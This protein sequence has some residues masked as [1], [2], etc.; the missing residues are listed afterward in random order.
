[1]ARGNRQDLYLAVN[2]DVRGLQNTVKVGRTVL[3]EFGSTAGNVLEEVERQFQKIGAGGL[4]A[5]L[6]ETER[7]YTET[8]RR[9]GAAAR[10]AANAP[11]GQA[12]IQILDANASRA[13]ADAA[14]NK[15]AALRIVAEAA[16]K[17]DQATGG[18]SAA[19]RAYAVAAATAAVE[20][21]KEAAAL[22][23]QA[24]IIGT[25]E[26]QLVGLTGA[27]Q[28]SRVMSGQ[29]RA[30]Y[31]QLSYQLG[32][33]SMQYS[34]GTSASIIFA[35]QSG[36]VIQAL[37]LI[38]G[39]GNKVLS[40]LGGPWGIA[41]SSALVVATPFVAKLLEGGD[42]AKKE[43]DQL[44]ENAEKAMSAADAKKIFAATEAGAIDDVRALTE[45][46]EKQNETLKTNAERLNI[47]AKQRL[48]TLQER[49][50]D[51]QSQ[52]DDANAA[53]AQVPAS[54]GVAGTASVAANEAR[55]RIQELEATLKRIDGAIAKA[56]AARLRT[57]ADLAGEAAQRAT[58]E[59][60]AINYRYEGANGLIEQAKKR[61][62]AEGTVDAVLTRQLKTLRDQQKA[63]VDTAQKREQA[64]KSSAKDGPLTTFIA[65]VNGTVSG[66][67]KEQRVG[68]QHAGIDYAV[69]VGTAVRAPAAGTIDVA[70]QRQGYGNAIYINFGGGT[71]A[72][73]GHLSKFNV[74]PGDRVEAGD[75]IGYS[76]GEPGTPGA[77]R[78][79]GAHLH[80]EV[81]RGGKAV[82]P[83]TGKF[84]TDSGGV[85]DSAARRQQAEARRQEAE[86]NRRVQ[87][88]DA[89]ASLLSQAQEARY[90][91]ERSRAVTIAEAA[92]LDVAAVERQRADFDRALQKGVE[93]ERW[94]QAEADAVKL[95]TAQNAAG[96]IAAIRLRET[97][98]TITERA[99][100]ER[101]ALDDQA[102]LLRL[103]GELATT[104]ADR[105][106]IARKLLKI[107]QDQVELALKAQIA[108][109]RDPARR[110]SLERR[111]AQ[112]PA[113][114]QLREQAL[115]R[116]NADPL[117]AYGQQ[118]VDATTDM[119]E[120][121]K[122]VAANG[123]GALEDASSRAA[124]RAVTD[125]LKIRGVAGDVV[126]GIIQDLVRLAVQKAIVSA[127]GTSFFGLKDGGL[128]PGFADGGLP[129]FAFGGRPSVDRG[130]IRG[131]GTGRSDSILALVGGQMPILVSN[132]EGIVN[133]RAVQQYWPLI[134]A[135]NKGTFPRFADGGLPSVPTLPRYPSIKAAQK[136]L[137]ESRREQLE[138]V[139][140]IRVSPTKEFDARMETLAVRTVGAAAEP[141]MAGAQSRTITRLRRPSLPGGWG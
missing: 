72:R 8:F 69:P 18:N 40:I 29:A 83:R 15:A 91:I 114:Y 68:H 52:L 89:Y 7:A 77:G 130:L 138:V 23:E 51:V 112:T 13:A 90:R 39:E 126:N 27:Q 59:V 44:R 117:Q 11:T 101:D 46:L 103:Q 4:P 61:A 132:G 78:S 64:A 124:A 120:A 41:L 71:T 115:D 66:R 128:V 109:E 48:E 14:T 122:G 92:D 54:G 28:R 94:T 75:I 140:N 123:F 74:K 98:A 5:G 104:A 125:L 9:I 30:G 32:D 129:G 95:I 131:P 17:A 1:M 81:R 62:I 141:I 116:Q 12:A 67:F 133:E 56:D 110:A 24:G 6:K 31:Q 58:D 35:Q 53:A 87:N 19:T 45:E 60:A 43:A 55:K 97:A 26:Q 70:G 102:S 50:A 121:L 86:E 106:A 96:E 10:E 84:P 22:R 57:R 136:A 139:G 47:R 42:A 63:E 108:S 33:I 88:A 25:V 100:L 137:G 76:G 93:L 73:F 3:N 135:M 2:G 36:Q 118:L 134:D 99:E 16:A 21:D 82:D 20:A 34:L 105:R 37:Q 65:P 80:Y 113:E 127:V 38:G 49:R 85:G 107:E 111:L 79:T 119:D